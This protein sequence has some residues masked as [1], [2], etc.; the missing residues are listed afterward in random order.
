MRRDAV[1]KYADNDASTYNNYNLPATPILAPAMEA[2]I[3]GKKYART[4]PADWSI[5]DDNNTARHINPLNYTGT[6]EH[7]S[8]KITEEELEEL[9][10]DKGIV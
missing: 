6:S 9:K 4:L 7:F 2:V 1:I 8:V 5:V 3:G 10:D